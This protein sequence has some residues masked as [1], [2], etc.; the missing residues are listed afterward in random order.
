MYTIQLS[1][2]SLE[3][4][5][6]DIEWSFE[7]VRFSD[8]LRDAFTSDFTLPKT[9]NNLALLE[10]VGLL[11][12]R[13]QP[14]GDH[15]EPC[16]FNIGSKVFSAYIQVVSVEEETI[17]I[18]L[19]EKLIP[20]EILDYNVA[21]LLRDTN[22]DIFV[23]NVNTQSAYPDSFKKYQYSVT[24]GINPNYAQ[25]HPSKPLGEVL[26]RINQAAGI[27][28][29]TPPSSHYLIATKK[30]VSPQNKIQVIEGHWTND[31]GN[32]A[33]LACGQHVVNDGEFSYS[34]D[35]TTITFNRDCKVSGRVY[36]SWKKKSTVTNSFYMYICRYRPSTPNYAPAYQLNSSTYASDV[37]YST[38]STTIKA[39]DTMRV[40]CNDTNKYDMLNFVLVFEY[41]D[42]NIV[43]EDYG[44]ELKY[45]GRT[46][47]LNVWTDNGM[48]KFGNNGWQSVGSQNG[49]YTYIYFDATTYG[50][51]H[52]QTGS[53][54][55]LYP[56]YINL[57]WCSLAY[58]G[59]WQNLPDMTVKEL[60]WGFCWA[61]G[62]KLISTHEH[63]GSMLY[64][65]L[66]YVPAQDAAVIDGHIT[67]TRISSDRL[68]R[69]NY[70]LCAG[71]EKSDTQ[72]ISEIENKWLE[73]EKVLHESPFT[74]S[75]PKY[76]QW[77]C[78][79]QYSDFSYDSDSGEYKA[80]FNDIDG[81]AIANVGSVSSMLYKFELNTMDFER[82]VQSIEVDIETYNDIKGLD[83]VFLEGRKYMIVEGSANLESGYSTVKA[84]LVPYSEEYAQPDHQSPQ[85]AE[86]QYEDDHEQTYH[87]DSNDDFDGDDDHPEYD[88]WD[89]QYDPDWD[90][91][92]NGY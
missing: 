43:D 60:M 1:E 8:G 9:Q 4:Y 68:G 82:I 44:T 3:V 15:I 63:N 55:T 28:M 53:P 13:Q 33:V 25:L 90:D 75:I 64:P 80:K 85:P 62:Y 46:P 32:F 20:S 49:C 66:Q 29:P 70:I 88:P 21:E 6:Q 61:E 71:Q 48:I 81:V 11:D 24:N 22:D 7:T 12:S 23:W 38:F 5:H 57:E 52:H 50:Y 17:T 73:K 18:C 77:Y 76:G 37:A 47:R 39:G 59:Y 41:S 72:P 10:C 2:G 79:P 65:V 14:L 27:N 92:D 16:A 91:F 86:N 26:Q 58:F 74:Y 40:Q 31:S 69:K 36:Y 78:I 67:Q 42:Y 56:A 30:T 54:N 19:Y 84:I 45:V 83:Y 51:Y 35:Q 89:D 34:P 87:Y